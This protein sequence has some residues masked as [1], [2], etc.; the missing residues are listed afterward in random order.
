MIE[1]LIAVLLGAQCAL[2]GLIYLALWSYNFEQLEALKD[3]KNVA[4]NISS[5]TQGIP[6]TVRASRYV[7]RLNRRSEPARHRASAA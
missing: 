3:I 5:L 2:L 1:I 6:I 7:L 4:I